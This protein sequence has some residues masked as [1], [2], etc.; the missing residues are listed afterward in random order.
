MEPN[1][2]SFERK[3]LPKLVK[4][5]LQT[6]VDC[7]YGNARIVAYAADPLTGELMLTLRYVAETPLRGKMAE[8]FISQVEKIREANPRRRPAEVGPLAKA[9]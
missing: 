1:K 8:R 2:S 6:T 9:G 7:E 4:R 3:D 5:N